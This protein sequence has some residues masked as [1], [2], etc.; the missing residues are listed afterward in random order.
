LAN[1]KQAREILRALGMPA[2]QQNEMAALTLIALCGL[3][4][5]DPWAASK[6]EARTV[7]KGIMNHVNSALNKSYAPNTR[8]TFR[9]QVLH[10]LVQGHIADY[11]AFEPGLPTNSPRA[12][13]SITEA[14]LSAIRLFDTPGWDAACHKFAAAEGSLTDTYARNRHREQVPL[15]TPN[16]NLVSLSPGKHNALQKAIVE[17]FA[18]RFAPGCRLLYLG[19][20]ASKDLIFD[21]DRLLA[22]G[23]QTGTREKLPD[24]VLHDTV[25]DWLYLIEAVASH[26]PM[27]PKRVVELNAMLKKRKSGVVYVTA[28][29]G[30]T[31]FKRHAPNI[32]WET[33]V[34][35]AEMP[36]HLIHFNGD[37]FMGPRERG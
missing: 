28:F 2:A 20:T 5:R 26:G 6:R 14:A 10:Q 1:V 25:R 19:D 27:T 35:L 23:F 16:G 18:P 3:G 30:M 24:I 29:P 34:W 11:N 17:Q 21:R 36:D 32:A 15:R 9:R 37:R 31:E 12:H 13:Y 22:L 33:E 8:E 4:R 7:T